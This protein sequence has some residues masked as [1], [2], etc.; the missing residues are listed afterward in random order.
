SPAPAILGPE[1]AARGG[2]EAAEGGASQP[3]AA[4][5]TA[6]TMELPEDQL[7]FSGRKAWAAIGDVGHH[8]AGPAGGAN[9]DGRA[10]WSVLRRVIEQVHVDLIQQN[11]GHRDQSQCR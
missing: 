11:L 1:P 10:G 5:T 2:D 7:L 3:D 9:L 8:L 4:G 6:A